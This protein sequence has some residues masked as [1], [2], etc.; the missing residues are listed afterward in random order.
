MRSYSFAGGENAEYF[1][2]RKGYF[3][4]NVQVIANANLEILDVVA[5]WPGSTHDQTILDQSRIRARFED[6]N[7]LISGDSGYANGAYL[8]T[9][10][11]NPELP[12]EVAYNEAQTRTRNPVERTFG[13][14]KRR[15]PILAI[16]INV[17]LSRSMPIIVATAVLHNIAVRGGDPLPPDDHVV[18]FP[19]PWEEL[20]ELGRIAGSCPTAR[21]LVRRIFSLRSSSLREKDGARL[22]RTSPDLTL[23]T[24]RS[25][26]PTNKEL[27]TEPHAAAGTLHRCEV[28][29]R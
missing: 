23:V 14:L 13:V 16:G 9:P 5:R 2:N 20:L 15:F 7:S 10:L 22:L 26:P 29:P 19:M 11:E 6:G 18:N 28:I 25:A 24:Q 1:R 17:R 3:P 12:E 8:M 27:S 21:A 4:L